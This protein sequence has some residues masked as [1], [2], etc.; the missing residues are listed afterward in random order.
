MFNF[1]YIWQ[2][3]SF[4]AANLNIY[5]RKSSTLM[6]M[7]NIKRITGEMECKEKHMNAL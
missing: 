5:S 2:R 4:I 1:H 7:S 6:F 3:I